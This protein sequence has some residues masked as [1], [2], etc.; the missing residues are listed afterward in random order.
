MRSLREEDGPALLEAI[1]TGQHHRC[2]LVWIPLMRGAEQPDLVARW[3]QLAESE[4]DPR[5][6]ADYGGL[7]RI[8]A[9]LADRSQV[10]N[11]GLEGYNVQTSQVVQEWIRQ[12]EAKG[13]ARGEAKGRAEGVQLLQA[14]LLQLLRTRFSGEPAGE[15]VQA[16]QAQQDLEVLGRW[17]DLAMTASSLEQ[18]QAGILA[19]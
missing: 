1:A 14:K 2:L 19:S 8:F 11:Q 18:A 10:W 12:G 15:V 16:V 17:F 5:L 13:E 3:R 4:P 9:E 7:A 6:R